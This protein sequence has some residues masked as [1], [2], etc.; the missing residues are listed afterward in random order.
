MQGP[1][2]EMRAA[3]GVAGN[4]ERSVAAG[5]A[6]VQELG[7]LAIAGAQ[8]RDYQ[9]MVS[10]L[11]QLAAEERA[12]NAAAA[13]PAAS[14]AGRGVPYTRNGAS[15]Y[16]AGTVLRSR[17]T[18]YGCVGPGGGFC[19]GMASGVRVFEGAAACSSD[20]PFGTRFTIQGDPTAR[21]YECLDRGHLNSTWVD[22]FFYSTSEGIAWQS[23][24][25]GTIAQIQIV[26]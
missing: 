16:A 8:E 9:A 25:G 26:N 13:A 12:R 20:L 15:G 23:M 5:S 4:W 11:N 1:A 7:A 6:P 10:A 24:I 18:I 19:G 21:V 2:S 22:V 3:A 17:I 14:A